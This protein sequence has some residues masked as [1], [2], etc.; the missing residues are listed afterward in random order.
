MQI[1]RLQ[2]SRHACLR[3]RRY[4]IADDEVEAIVW[5]PA[6]REVTGRGVNHYGSSSDGRSFRV[7][8][9]PDER[10]VITVVELQRRENRRR[11]S[12]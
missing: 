8:T 6:H 4:G 12:R 7:S 11:S 9:S 1:P 3:M 5:Y 10:S 2:Y